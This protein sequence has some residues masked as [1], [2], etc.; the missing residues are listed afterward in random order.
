MVRS[1]RNLQHIDLGFRSDH[2]LS[3]QISLPES[4]YPRGDQ[5]AAFF[6][7]AVQELRSAPA[8]EG[9]ATVSGRPVAERTVDLTSRDFT[10]EGQ[11]T[12]DA[13]PSNADFR[14]V[15]PGYLETIGA[16]ILQGRSFS[17]QDGAGAPL[18]AIINETMAKMF[19]PAGDA[20]GH[21]IRLGRQY[22]RPDTF[23]STDNFDRS[24]TIVGIASDVRQ[25]RAIDAPVHPEFYMPLAQQANPPRTMTLVL[26]STLDPAT[27]TNSARAAIRAVDSEQPIYDISTMDEVVADSFGPARL[28]LFLLVFLAGVVLVLACTGLYATLSYSVTQRRRELGI[29]I[30][31]GATTHDILRLVVLEGAYLAFAGVVLGLVIAF[32]L[33]RLMQSLLYHVSGSDPVTLVGAAAV[34]VFVAAVASFVP[35]RRASA[36]DPISVLRTE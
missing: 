31:V 8:V 11:P 10:I 19:W 33:T 30:A 25:I 1:Y 13:R 36:V 14:V 4:K 16:R 32:A 9:S 18:A 6:S 15:S 22:A 26:R 35:A 7:R 5:R 3:F 24:L 20:V 17:D 34:L 21:R 12:E 23:A 29:R 28:T 27:V 2:L